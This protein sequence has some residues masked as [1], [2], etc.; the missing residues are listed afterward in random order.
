MRWGQEGAVRT[1]FGRERRQPQVGVVGWKEAKKGAREEKF[2]DRENS[3]SDG[4][5]LIHVLLLKIS[6]FTPCIM[7]L[8]NLAE[9]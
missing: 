8:R 2:G 1:R 3:A 5:G 4:S 7:K 9:F 6:I